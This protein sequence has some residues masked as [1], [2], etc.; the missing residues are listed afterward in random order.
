[1]RSWSL[2]F[3]CHPSSCLSSLLP[4]S[5]SCWKEV[6][7]C[8]DS[9]KIHNLA[10][11]YLTRCPCLDVHVPISMC[12]CVCVFQTNKQKWPFPIYFELFLF[13]KVWHSTFWHTIFWMLMV[14]TKLLWSLQ[15][16]WSLKKWPHLLQQSW[17]ICAFIDPRDLKNHSDHN[18]WEH[19]YHMIAGIT[20]VVHS[21]CCDNM[22]TR[23]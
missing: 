20:E 4:M 19:S 5:I 3:V 14:S 1:M 11:I 8:L 7:D 18:C 17:G 2:P 22:K 23:L 21:D 6:W 15:S 9:I 12:L 16:S 10:L 13:S